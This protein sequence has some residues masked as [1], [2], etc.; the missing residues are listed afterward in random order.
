MKEKLNEMLVS[1]AIQL[2]QESINELTTKP[3]KSLRM[4]TYISN[5]NEMVLWL[6]DGRHYISNQVDTY[7]DLKKQ[8]LDKSKKTNTISQE[9]YTQA[10][11]NQ[12]F[13]MVEY[14]KNRDYLNIVTINKVKKINLYESD[15]IKKIKNIQAKNSGDIA[16]LIEFYDSFTDGRGVEF[17][18]EVMLP[19]FK[20]SNL[21]KS[22]KLGLVLYGRKS[23]GKSLFF[24]IITM[25]LGLEN[26]ASCDFKETDLKFNSFMK[27]KLFIYSN[28]NV[29]T[30]PKTI[31][32]LKD[33]S[34]SDYITIEG[35]GVNQISNY[36]YHAM[37]GISTEEL[38]VELAESNE[39]KRFL[40]LQGSKKYT[41]KDYYVFEE[42]APTIR[43]HY[44]N[45]PAINEVEL[46]NFEKIKKYSRVNEISNETL[47]TLA[48]EVVVNYINDYFNDVNIGRINQ[49]LI[50]NNKSKMFLPIT[51]STL[52]T[53]TRHLK[54][55]TGKDIILE[56]NPFNDFETFKAEV[57][58]WDGIEYSKKS[59][60]NRI[61]KTFNVRNLKIDLDDVINNKESRENLDNLIF[62]DSLKEEIIDEKQEEVKIN[63]NIEEKIQKIK[64][65]QPTPKHANYLEGLEKIEKSKVEKLLLESKVP[66]RTKKSLLN[67]IRVSNK[68]QWTSIR[69][70]VEKTIKIYEAK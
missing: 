48:R 64:E 13:I 35:K 19:V 53:F 70:Y 27:K 57:I 39:E 3:T 29:E 47:G 24:K 68:V 38:P 49:D 46:S 17:D 63:Q 15:S 25:I 55:L 66:E 18:K 56:G 14:V 33:L 45:H 6:H 22:N 52:A 30:T 5:E 40:F 42:L 61:K 23:T 32:K 2:D 37:L 43:Y 12:E 67:S 1:T 65:S 8:F 16:P 51:K 20:D 11:R 60:N 7:K 62:S 69:P 28:D 41:E 9:D 31:S 4:Y 34:T 54:E 50:G 58:K 59:T 44:E 21:L 26:T 10:I 36:P